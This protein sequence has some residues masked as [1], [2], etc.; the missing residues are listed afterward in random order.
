MKKQ[1]RKISRG[2][3]AA[4][5]AA[6]VTG[7]IVVGGGVIGNY[8]YNMA[9]YANGSFQP[10]IGASQK[11]DEKKSLEGLDNG[12][13][14]LTSIGA[15]NVYFKYGSSAGDD[16]G[17]RLHAYEIVNTS[18]RSNGMWI[19]AA[20][21][22]GSDGRS[23]AS[24]AKMYYAMGFSI[25]LPDAR[26][27]GK[28]GGDYRGM[29][30]DDRIDYLHWIKKINKEH[31]SPEIALFGVS[32]GASTVMMTEGEDMPS[33]VKAVIEDCGYASIKEELTYVLK[34]TFKLPSFPIINFASTVTHIRAGYSLISDGSCVE[35]VA[36]SDTPTLFIHGDADKFVP[37]SQMKE[38]CTA[39]NCEK[40]KL[41]VHGA[42]HGQ[43]ASVDR[44]GYCKK[45]QIFL[46]KYMGGT[47][48]GIY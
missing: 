48:H 5:I 19:I 2:K 42:G 34:S 1:K 25:L 37:L 3:K 29:G 16:A 6:I 44:E 40:E 7:V 4:I 21:G 38:L 33:N 10:N 28:S 14:W 24:F 39:A 17:L 46:S 32:M 36:K 12:S 41:I 13:E 8:F 22:Y 35:A 20:H 9:I 23:M 15:K 47:V 26:G 43:S 11:K 31:N 30:W 27:H 18:A 45:V